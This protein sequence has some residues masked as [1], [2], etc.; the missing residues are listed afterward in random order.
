MRCPRC[1][2]LLILAACSSGHEASDSRPLQGGIT[3]PLAET[4]NGTPV[5]QALLDAVARSRDLD[6]S[7][8]DQRAQALNLL[9]DYVLLA[10]AAQRDNLFT[11]EMFRADVEVARLQG[12]GN[13][14]IG[15]DRQA[16]LT[17]AA[18]KAEYDAQVARSGKFEF[19]FAQLL[20]ENEADALKAQAELASGKSFA[21]VYDD[22]RARARQAK[23]FSRVRADQV[24]DELAGALAAMKPGETT[25]KP[26]KTEFGWHI[27]HLDAVNPFV[28]PLYDQLKDSIR[29]NLV[30]RRGRE[31]LHKLKEQASIDY[32]PGAVPP[33]P[34]APGSPSDKIA[35]EKAIEAAKKRN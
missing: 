31:R 1:L 22:W 14:T 35:V 24:P 23:A 34:E 5:P 15:R 13:A 16:P 18:V 30:L 32:P 9:T 4:V 33:A 2:I 3:G 29:Q 19:D 20:F 7:K 8:P 10:Q 27:V 25:R 17:D 26:V 12:V 21:G 11:D 6:L 28:A